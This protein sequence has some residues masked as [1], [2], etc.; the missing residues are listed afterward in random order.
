[1]LAGGKSVR[2]LPLDELLR[3]PMDP[4]QDHVLRLAE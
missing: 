1:V 3:L 2:T 4:S